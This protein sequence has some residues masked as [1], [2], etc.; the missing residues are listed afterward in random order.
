[1]GWLGRDPEF[2][3]QVEINV[4]D[5]I[6]SQAENQLSSKRA[7]QNHML[8]YNLTGD[9][10]TLLPEYLREEN[11]ATIKKNIDAIQTFQGYAQEAGAKYGN[12]DAMNLSNI[13]EYMTNDIFSATGEALLKIANPGARIAYWNLMVPRRLSAQFTQLEYQEKMSKELMKQDKGFY[14]SNFITE[15]LKNNG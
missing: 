5:F 4:A 10:G 7:H 14:Y 9:F 8:R 15:K 1:M 11:F 13:F 12:F 6:F 3:R 2:L